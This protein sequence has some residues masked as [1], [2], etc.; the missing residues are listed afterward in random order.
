MSTALHTA[1]S[2]GV[3]ISDLQLKDHERNTGSSLFSGRIFWV[4]LI[5]LLVG[6]AWWYQKNNGQLPDW[7]AGAVPEFDTATV[8]L[9]DTEDVALELSGF[10]VP[11]R[12]VNVSPRIPGTV[13]KLTIDVG[14]TVKEGELLAQLDDITYQADVLQA[15]AALKAARSRLEEI[16]AG[17][18]VEEVEQARTAVDGAKSKVAF[19]RKEVARAESLTDSVSPAELDSMKS[20]LNDA[21]VNARGMEQK[22]QLLIKGVRVERRQAAEADIQQAEA[23]LAKAKYILDN[24]KIFAPL[25]GTVLEKNTQVGEILRPEVLSTSLCILADLSTLEVEVDVQERDLQKVE[26]GRICRIIPDAY[27]D[28]KYEGKIDRIQPMVNRSRGVV[29]VTIRITEPD[30]YLLPDM[31]VRAII[32]NPPVSDEVA[33]TLWIPEAAVVKDGEQTVV[34]TLEQDQAQ[35]KVVQL[36]ATEGKKSQVTSGLKAGE[37]VV[38]PGK[39]TLIDGQTIRTKSAAK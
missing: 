39:Q 35:R 33:E 17:A 29:R 21:E 11:Y 32:E 5:A 18:L 25:D 28:R 31:N 19:L 30:R 23:V 24:T 20:S 13:M 22:L 4:L 26:V 7:G 14:Q 16:K 38:L 6:G 8:S 9:K 2:P 1:S 12:K 10:I 37:I 36:G 15:D 34:F 27:T 3:N